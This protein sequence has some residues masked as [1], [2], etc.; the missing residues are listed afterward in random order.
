ME[1][2]IIE[3]K[4]N[5]ADVYN[6]NKEISKSNLNVLEINSGEEDNSF[7]FATQE[8]YINDVL[9]NLKEKKEKV[10]KKLN[11]E[12]NK[13]T[14]I[15]Y[16]SINVLNNSEHIINN[17]KN[18]INRNSD[19][20]QNLNSNILT[21]K[22]QIEINHNKNTSRKNTINVLKNTLFFCIIIVGL[23]ILSI[24]DII[25]NKLFKILFSVLGLA[26]AIIL[27]VNYLINKNRHN[28]RWNTINWNTTD[29][30]ED[31]DA[32]YTSA[33]TCSNAKEFFF[34]S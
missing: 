3:I 13:N 25:S 6:K 32:T 1:T 4:K 28:L 27:L 15:K 26:Y 12:Y 5:K 33:S 11:N 2:N 21:K 23:L 29:E 24:K 31:D 20:I 14:K 22:R 10:L 30:D 8:D 19:K 34:S 17:Q 7:V 9:N 16:R 18:E